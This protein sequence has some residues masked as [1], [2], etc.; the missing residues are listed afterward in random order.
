MASICGQ[1]LL[2]S[3]S[4]CRGVAPLPEAC[5]GRLPGTGSLPRRRRR[6]IA[7]MAG[8]VTAALACC[9]LLE[10]PRTIA[11]TAEA[12]RWFR[13]WRFEGEVSEKRGFR[14]SAV[15]GLGEN[16]DLRLQASKADGVGAEV[17]LR[18]QG[19]DGPCLALAASG[20]TEA[21]LGQS[22]KCSAK[23]KKTVSG[24]PGILPLPPLPGLG[25]GENDG[26]DAAA[27]S[28]AELAAS[29][30]TQDGLAAD[31]RVMQTLSE[32]LALAVSLRLTR[33]LRRSVFTEGSLYR[34]SATAEAHYKIGGGR[35]V[36]A[37]ETQGSRGTQLTA[38]YRYDDA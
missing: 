28:E 2:A 3:A 19:E 9:W 23:V 6:R 35:L 5:M 26:S 17:T 10:A 16:C 12:S 13:D 37:I 7:A 18:P 32:D 34:A 21:W 4:R 24:M 31:A 25:K 22:V 11:D 38:S 33:D 36:G 1:T 14:G 30:S 20:D 27:T 15:C 29:I 8:V